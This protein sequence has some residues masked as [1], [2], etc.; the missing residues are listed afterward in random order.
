M[1]CIARHGPYQF[2]FFSNENREPPH[3]HV[4]R[5]RVSA[6]FWLAP[7]A[8]AHNDGFNGHELRRIE[9]IVREHQLRFLEAWHAYFTK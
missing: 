8:L 4:D 6:K 5:E 3:V 1:P 2:H 7:V 9:A